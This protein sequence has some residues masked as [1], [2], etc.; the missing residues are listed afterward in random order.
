MEREFRGRCKVKPRATAPAITVH[1][2]FPPPPLPFIIAKDRRIPPREELRHCALLNAYV[3]SNARVQAIIGRDE[4]SPF[5]YAKRI[6]L[7]HFLFR[8]RGWHKRRRERERERDSDGEIKIDRCD[9]SNEETSWQ[10]SQSLPLVKVHFILIEP[11]KEWEERVTY[12]V[13]IFIG[14]GQFL[15]ASSTRMN[16][17]RDKSAFALAAVVDLETDKKKLLTR[18][19]TDR[20]DAPLA[21]PIHASSPFFPIFL[22]HIIHIYIYVYTRSNIRVISV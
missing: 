7:G 9:A 8:S 11:E 2:P 6:R 10:I 22:Q 18:G 16:A 3:F 13:P 14:R 4:K 19:G 17:H 12:I 1:R 21:S 15:I 5:F 20:N